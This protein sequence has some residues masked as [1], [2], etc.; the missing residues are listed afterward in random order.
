MAT[1]GA[2]VVLADD[3]GV[4]AVMTASWLKQMGWDDVFVMESETGR[5]GLEEGPYRAE[6]LGLEAIEVDELAPEALSQALG[7]GA[8][9]A[10]LATSREYRQG[11]VPGARFAMRGRLKRHLEPLPAGRMLVLTSP[12][13]RLAR[14]AAAEAESAWDGPVQVLRGGTEGWREAG[15]P[16]EEDPELL[17]GPPADVHL[18]PYEHRDDP[19]GAMRRY[20]EWEVD[21]LERVERAGDARFR[22]IPPN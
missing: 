18:K 9:V 8:V 16:I 22:F 15:L 6:V 14:L 11:H 20:L 13:G 1:R 17:A 10:D 4:R 7:E 21:L 3:T 5:G 2:R 19:A 12:D